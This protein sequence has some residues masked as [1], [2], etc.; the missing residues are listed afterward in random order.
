VSGTRAAAK[1]LATA[2]VATLCGCAGLGA[3][4]AVPVGND[5]TALAS[6]A[7]GTA[8]L[9]GGM[10]VS[11]VT[12]RSKRLTATLGIQVFWDSTG[13]RAKLAAEANRI[14]DYV[15]DLGANSVA[16]DFFFYTDGEHP[17]YV[18]GVPGSTPSP[19][20][21]AMVIANAREHGLRVLVRPL[22]NDANITIV[23]GDWRGSIEPWSVAS[24][25][26]SYYS[27]LRPYLAAAQQSKATAFGIDTELDSLAADHREWASLQAAAAKLFKGQLVYAV[28]YG[29]WQKDRPD[30]PVPDAA[31]DAYPLLG[32]PGSATVA[33]LTAAWVSWLQGHRPAAVLKRTVLQEVG[34]AAVAGAYAG[35]A[36]AAPGRAPVDLSVQRKWFAAACAAAKQAHLAGIYFFDVNS[37]DDPAD[38]AAVARYAP[39]SFIGRSDGVIE[40]CFASGWS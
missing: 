1:L 30:E 38:L 2:V 34:I 29:L 16:I 23:R 12:A 27:F 10:P 21:I 18:Y 22:L 5:W 4:P 33:E 39:G 14:F 32:L 31:V 17:R 40:A 36:L 8:Q 19:A 20:T 9:I 15:V 28:N 11:K 25:F 24:W 7:P 3:G 35:P 6:P 37:T 13:P 26:T